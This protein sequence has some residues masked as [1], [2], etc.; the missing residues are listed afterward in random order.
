MIRRIALASLFVFGALA[1]GA[2]CSLSFTSM[3]FG[4]YTGT[5]LNGTAIGTVKCKGAWNIPLN[6]GTGVG[7]TITIR[8]MTGPGGAVLNYQIFQ[9]AARTTIWGNTSSTQVSGSGNATATAYGQILAGQYV[10]PGTYTDT[11][12]SSTTSFTVTAIVQANCSISATALAFGTYS[13]ALINS[14]STISV[15][16]TSTTAYNVGLNPGVATGATVTN[17]MMTG[18]SASHLGYKLFRDSG[19]T[20][21]W[22]NTVGTDTVAGTGS[23]VVQSLPV[24]GQ[25][26]A[27]ELVVPGGYS[28]TITATITY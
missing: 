6:A 20:S 9:D 25:I 24:Y 22:G 8:K 10:V 14:T 4:T 17:R 27:G 13:G 23:G 21:N 12:S 11:V 19:R 26:P 3:S 2:Q 18:P 28:D 5:A 16:C 7:A 15:T 1:A